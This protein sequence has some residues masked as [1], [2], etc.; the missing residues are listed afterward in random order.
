MVIVYGIHNIGP[1]NSDKDLGSPKIPNV[2]KCKTE[3]YKNANCQPGCID[4]E[5]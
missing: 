5:K 4:A 2:S 3:L 1:I